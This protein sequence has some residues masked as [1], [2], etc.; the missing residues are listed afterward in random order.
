MLDSATQS[1]PDPGLHVV[2]IVS[3][4][5]S[6]EEFVSRFRHFSDGKS[7]FLPTTHP[8]PAGHRSRFT[9][10]LANGDHVLRG[11]GE[12]IES[13]THASASGTSRMPGMRVRFLE[14]DAESQVVVQWLFAER[15]LRA[16]TAPLLRVAEPAATQ[17]ANGTTGHA[18]PTSPPQPSSAAGWL[19][20]HVPRGAIAMA[21]GL[22][23]AYL[24]WGCG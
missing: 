23:T 19:R 8:V 22:F 9:V 15:Q 18:Q 24:L 2:Q 4:C 13:Q 17:L 12:V 21:A 6:V 1:R 16:A 20:R 11:L 7:I 3:D 5:R 10:T 14:L